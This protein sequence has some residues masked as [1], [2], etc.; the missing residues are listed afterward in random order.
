MRQAVSSP[1]GSR[2]LARTRDTAEALGGPRTRAAFMAQQAKLVRQGLLRVLCPE[3]LASGS[4]GWKSAPGSDERLKELQEN[5]NYSNGIEL[6][7]ML[8]RVLTLSEI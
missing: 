8:R 1:D 7:Y 2:I 6:W 4:E 5:G 3:M